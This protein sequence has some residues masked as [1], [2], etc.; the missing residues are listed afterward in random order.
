M[1]IGS[2]SP[3]IRIAP[4]WAELPVTPFESNTHLFISTATFP[5]TRI[6]PPKLGAKPAPFPLVSVR[7]DILTKLAGD[8]IRNIL[9]APPPLIV[10]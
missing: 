9:V 10:S 4:P 8:N 2:L 1:I 5:L 3:E 7:S 6:A